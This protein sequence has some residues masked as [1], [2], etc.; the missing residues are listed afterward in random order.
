MDGQ[1]LALL[2]SQVLGGTRADEEGL[3]LLRTELEFSAFAG[4][5][6]KV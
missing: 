3:C 2:G 6:S 5:G 1:F 4:Q